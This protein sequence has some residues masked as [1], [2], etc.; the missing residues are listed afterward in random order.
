MTTGARAGNDVIIEKGLQPG[1]TVI[2]DG[3]QK[4]RP[5]AP[6]NPV[7]LAAESKPPSQPTVGSPG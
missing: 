2:V 7:P 5:G 1:D 4:I 3:A 6:V